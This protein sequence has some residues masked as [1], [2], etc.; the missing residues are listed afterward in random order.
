L[1]SDRGPRLGNYVIDLGIQRTCEILTAR[2]G[3]K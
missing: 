2:L 1:H 3:H